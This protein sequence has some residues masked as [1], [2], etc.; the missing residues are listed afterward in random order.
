[1]L[2][3]SRRGLL[4]SAVPKLGSPNQ[5]GDHRRRSERQLMEQL[6]YNLLFR[7]CLSGEIE[8]K[9]TFVVSGT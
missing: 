5:R 4:A 9:D 6:D 1:M 3:V 8:S 2:T 7:W